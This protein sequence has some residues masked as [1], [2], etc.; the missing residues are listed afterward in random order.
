M[1]QLELI[2]RAV[3]HLLDR[4]NDR[5][6]SYRLVLYTLMTLLAWALVGS[7]FDKVPYQAGKIAVS[8]AVIVGVCWLANRLISRFLDIPSNNESGL[9]T[10]F[11]LT[12]ILSPVSDV[13][14]LSVLATVSLAAIASKY[15]LTFQ[16]GHIFNPA[17]AG[18]FFAGA[19]FHQYPAWWV[20]TKFITPIAVIG[21]LLILRKMNRFI[22]A[23]VFLA[24]FLLYLIYGTSAG[25]NL[26]FL[27]LELIST[28][29]LFF[30]FIMLTEPLTSPVK[31]NIGLIYAIVVG[32]LYTATKLR[33]SPEEALLAGNIL[34]FILARNRR[35]EVKFIRRIE[36]ADGIYSYLFSKPKGFKFRAGQYMEWTLSHNKSDR[37]GNRRYFTISSSPTEPGLMFT[38]KQPEKPSSFKQMLT[39]LKPGDKILASRLAGDFALPR[40]P[41]Q[42]VA[43]LAGGVG[44]TPFRSMLKY[45]LD[46]KQPRDISLV[47]SANSDSEFAYRQL[48]KDAAG[49]GL[50]ASLATGR[51]DAAKI[52][53]AVPDFKDRRF[54]I[55]GPYGFVGAMQT[56]LI[57]AGL[58]P[59]QIVTDYFPGYGA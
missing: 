45:T 54:Y 31:L 9:I 1:K 12:L 8:A 42:K 30:S 23:G 58:T 37:R 13:S 14:G 20:G 19:V 41:G 44:I 46:S 34:T 56:E 10:G 6:T 26:H 49:Q 7:L 27:W 3:L 15:V 28:Q 32:I 50:K 59:T 25:S 33:F 18:A 36:E 29:A 51:L 21:G 55:S 2:G 48:I 52:K 17:A 22:M 47:Y 11:I 4:K 5:V 53:A 57:N 39:E 24:T 40:D 16:K 38:I 35:Y 43:M